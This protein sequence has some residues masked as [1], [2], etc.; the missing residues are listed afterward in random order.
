MA[1]G[2]QGVAA[3]GKKKNAGTSRDE[4][5][6]TQQTRPAPPSLRDLGAACMPVNDP[7]TV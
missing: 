4:G 1:Q 6:S 5:N 2:I 3:D 7:A